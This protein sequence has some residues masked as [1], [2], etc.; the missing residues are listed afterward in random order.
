M[1]EVTVKKFAELVGVPPERLVSQL[2]DAGVAIDDENGVISDTEKVE[3]LDFLRKNHGIKQPEDAGAAEPRKITLKR[4]TMSELKQK[5]PAGR[6]KV[7]TVNVEVRKKRTYVKRSDVMAKEAER[8]EKLV[9][10]RSDEE[11]EKAKEANLLEEALLKKQRDQEQEEQRRVEAEKARVAEE[12][13]RKEEAEATRLKAEQAEALKKAQQASAAKPDPQQAAEDSKKSKR[14]GGAKDKGSHVSKF[15]RKELHVASE[16]TGRRKKK[17]RSRTMG[18]ASSGGKHGFARPTAPVVR[19]VSIPETLT[20][21]ELAQRMSVKAAEV[22]KALMGMG[23]MA[24][25][26]QPIDQETAI[27]LVEEMGHI[28]KPLQENALEEA[29]GISEEVIGERVSRAPVVTIMGHVDHGKTTLLDYI[30][31]TKVVDGEAGGITQHIGAYY[32]DT[33]KGMISFLDTPGHAAFT[34]MRARGSKVTDIVIVVVAADDGMMPQTVEA[35]QHAQAAGVAIIVAIN[36]MD[37]PD[38]DPERV[39]QELSTKEVIPEEWGGSTMFVKLSAKSGEGVDALLDAIL[40]QAEMLE[41]SAV[42]DCPAKGV[43][44]ESALDKGRGP[45]ATVLVQHGVLRK[46]DVILSGHEYGRVRA[47]LD[48]NGKPVNEA[49]PSFPVVILGLSG[50]PNAGDELTCVAD[51]RAAREIAESRETKTRE[52][53]FAHQQSTKLEEMFSKMGKGAVQTLNLIVKADVQGSVEA[54]KD[55]LLKIS[56][57]EVQINVVVSGVGG[58]RESDVNLAMA[59]DCIL[60][61]FNVRADASARRIAKSADLEIRYYSIIYDVIDDVKKAVSGMLAPEIREQI[62]GYAEVRDVFRSPKFGAIAGCLVVEGLI[63]RSAPIRVLRDEVV[64]YEGELESLRR[65]KDDVNEVRSG[66][67]CGI[68]VKNYNDVVP[69]DRI[70]VFERIEVAREL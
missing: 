62:I 43:V 40:L 60:I 42:Q 63:K 9:K 38:A 35:I 4:R 70:E 24:T 32:V 46:G 33:D 47:M 59:S 25:I 57:D 39:M 56:N 65:F 55:S 34:A 49:G 5:S 37:K 8:L 16:K 14:R 28:A 11:A 64:I 7:N 69:G 19:E 50:T 1:S 61:G 53:R 26:N 18:A 2:R 54:L 23:S 58:I 21:A 48:A 6:G 13:R 10:E 31:R 17:V 27:L 68:G 3:L 44:I 30:R 67:E 22:I 51:E 36:K 29:A 20:V 52:T 15:G 66:V 45:V 41:L 12:A